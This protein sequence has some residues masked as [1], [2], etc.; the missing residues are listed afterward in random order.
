MN[1][2]TSLLLLCTIF[3]FSTTIFA[4]DIMITSTMSLKNDGSGTM[5]LIY[6]AKNSDVKGYMVG[7]Y[8]FAPKVMESY[9]SS[10]N[11][12]VKNT[13]FYKSKTDTTIY[14]ASM[15]IDFKDINK[16]REARGFAE[17]NAS[18]T[19]GASANVFKWAIRPNSQ[20]TAQ[21]SEITFK[22]TFEDAIINSNGQKVEGN[23]VTWY[24]TM[25]DIDPSKELIL[26]ANIKS[27]GTTTTS[28]TKTE[29][30]SCGL[31]GLELPFMLLAGLVISKGIK[32]KTS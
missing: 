7:N 18:W 32:R 16:L 28:G 24:K 6:R 22:V 11:S 30:K 14:N 23:T 13:S 2:K 26:T 9:F 4:G 12:T 20:A 29:E 15:T 27:A 5:D 8:P 19:P 21:V 17:I 25:K 10:S 3:F 31:F 1:F